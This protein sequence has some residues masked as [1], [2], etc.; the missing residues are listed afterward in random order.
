MK[1]VI[2]CIISLLVIQEMTI[3]Q[4]SFTEK[5]SL[6]IEMWPLVVSA[7]RRRPPPTPR[8][9]ETISPRLRVPPPPY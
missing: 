5:A 9:A 4:N 8:P 7:Q 1:M 6:G 3:F 2:I